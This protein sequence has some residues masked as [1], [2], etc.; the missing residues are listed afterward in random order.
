M[1]GNIAPEVEQDSISSVKTIAFPFQKGS[2]GVPALASPAGVTFTRITSLVNTAR[3]E[4]VMSYDYGVDLYQY[5]FS[6]LTAIDKIRMTSSIKTAVER[7]IPGVTI[8]RVIPGPTEYDSGI[9]T[10][11]VI[12]VFWLEAGRSQTGQVL[13]AVN[14]D[15]VK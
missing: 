9:G 8:E 2:F 14:G 6:N 5:N 12:E 15:E 11:A 7:F 4:K 13:F 10:Y 3:G 1:Y